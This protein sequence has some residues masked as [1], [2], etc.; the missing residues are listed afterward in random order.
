M[1]KNCPYC[2]HAL[3]DAALKCSQCNN[4]VPNELFNKLCDEDVI[5]IK[6]NN[7]VPHTPS[8]IAVGVMGLLNKSKF[9]QLVEESYGKKLEVQQQFKLLVFESYCFFEA[10][11]LHAKFKRERR[12]EIIEMFKTNLLDGI[13]ESPTGNAVR[14]GN[15][16]LI[17]TFKIE[18]EELYKQFDNVSND[19]GTDMPS[20]IR[21]TKALASIVYGDKRAT[22]INGLPLYMHMLDIPDDLQEPFG[23]IFLVDDDDFDWRKIVDEH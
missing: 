19:L 11:C 21:N 3:Q 6:D 9:K 18:G 14:I 12:D 15:K 20:Q 8:L 4:W 2:G 10:I 22:I 13:I 7:L 23:E 5:L 16:N 1:E 17:P